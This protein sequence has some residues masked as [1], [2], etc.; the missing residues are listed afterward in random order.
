MGSRQSCLQAEL[1]SLMLKRFL[2]LGQGDFVRVLL[3]AVRPEL[4]KPA[5]EVS[6]YVLQVRLGEWPLPAPSAC[7][8]PAAWPGE[9][10][11]L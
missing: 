6:Q 3:D 4:D 7:R 2:L 5:G 10:L 9:G 1:G 8:C 11:F